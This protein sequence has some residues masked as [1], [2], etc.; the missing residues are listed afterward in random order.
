MRK[1]LHIYSLIKPQLIG[2]FSSFLLITHLSIAQDT[3]ARR[4]FKQFE[5]SYF[6]NAIALPLSGK[7]GIFHSPTHPGLTVGTSLYWNNSPKNEL[8]QSFR[9]GVYYQQF[10]QTGIQLYS[11]FNYRYNFNF[12]L[13]VGANLGVGYLHSFRDLEQF[14]LDEN[15][16]YQEVAN[17]G[18]MGLMFPIGL[19]LSCDLRKQNV[20]L[21]LFSEY[22]IWFQ[23]PFSKEYIPVLPNTSLHVGAIVYFK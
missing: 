1:K 4:S 13:G 7:W 12:G 8:F 10:V 14:E 17:W 16:E 3:S 15:G 18:R 11:T 2:L 21:R 19:Q 9:L 6:N 20:P 23:T 22:Q 5:I